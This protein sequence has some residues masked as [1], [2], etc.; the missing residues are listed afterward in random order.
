MHVDLRTRYLGLELRNPL[1]VSASP[2]TGILHNIARLEQAGAGAVVL[3]SLF[4]EQI[5]DADSTIKSCQNAGLGNTAGPLGRTLDS[6][7]M[8]P[9]G[10]LRHIEDAKKSVPIPVIAS[11]NG[12]RVGTWVDFARLIQEAGADALELNIYSISTDPE[13]SGADIEEQYVALVAAVCRQVSIPVAVKLGPFFTSLPHVA[14]RIVAAGAA[15]LVLFNRFVQPD[16]DASTLE[17]STSLVLSNRDEL[18]LPLRWIAILRGQTAASLAATSGVAGAEDV[19]KLLLAGADVAM[20]ASI[21]M[22]EGPEHLH[23]M[24][25]D[26][27]GWLRSHGRESPDQIRGL[28]CPSRLSDPSIYERA[29][30]LE[31]V[32]SFTG[33][34]AE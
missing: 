33:D 18:R 32:T 34:K 3:P 15:G 10:Y 21:L 29:N 20:V 25:A 12:C 8:G 7:N 17:V 6:Y 9:D 19:I 11:L 28:V 22:R 5:G 13:I 1:V 23:R 27:E 14:R 24:L 26:L 2:M 4:Q 16:I 30:Y 31:T